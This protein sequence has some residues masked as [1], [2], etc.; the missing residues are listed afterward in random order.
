MPSFEH[1][2]RVVVLF[3]G[4]EDGEGVE[5]FYKGDDTT[6][7]D[8][9]LSGPNPTDLENAEASGRLIIGR[10]IGFDGQPAGYSTVMIDELVMW[11]KKLTSEQIEQLY[12]SYNVND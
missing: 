2:T 3:H 6:Q 9:T 1:W 12:D 8:R 4:I 7:K 10:G 5:V 11:D